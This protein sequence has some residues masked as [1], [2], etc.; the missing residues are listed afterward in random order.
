[1]VGGVLAQTP[2][3]CLGTSSHRQSAL[4]QPAWQHNKQHSS[5]RQHSLGNNSRSRP[6]LTP[7]RVAQ[8]LGETLT[9]STAS[10]ATATAAPA[11]DPQQQALEEEQL[12]AAVE[13]EVPVEVPPD[14]L[15]EFEHELEEDLASVAVT[16]TAVTGVIIFWR[17]V[18]SLLD[19]L[20][21]DSIFG[22]I[23]CI[24]VGLTIVLGIRLSGVKVSSSFWPPS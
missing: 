11:T 3:F 1:M 22:D 19:Y 7:L 21:G 23:C 15:T 12:R 5:R 16:L 10:A 13:Q 4:L 9:S 18:W 6:Q 17:G 8:Q 20:L 24:F 14:V 2:S